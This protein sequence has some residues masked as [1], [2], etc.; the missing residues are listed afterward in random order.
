MKISNILFGCLLLVA[1]ASCDESVTIGSSVIEDEIE[2]VMDSSYT[3]SGRSIENTRIQSRTVTQ[4]LGSINAKEY[5]S[6]KSDFVT[7]LM[8]ANKIDTT[9]VTAEDIDSIKMKL[10]MPLGG[11][12]G[13]SIVPMGLNVYRLN[14]QLPSPIYSD[15]NPAE[16]YSEADLLCSKIYTANALGE[17]DSV[18]EL[19]YRFI[20]IDLPVELGREFFN[21]YKENPEI[22]TIPTEFAKWFPGLYVANKFGNGRVIQIE[23][24]EIKLFYHKKVPIEYTDRDTTYYKEGNYFAVTPEIITNN[25]IRLAMADDLQSMADNGEAVIVAPTG[26]DVELVFPA[27]E[28]IE[29]YRN[30]AGNLSVVNALSFEIPAE[31]ITNEYGINPPPYLLFVKSSEKDSFFANSNITDEVSSFYA[32]YNESKNKYV[33][34]DMRQYII[35]MLKKDEITDEDVTFTLTPINI[36]TESSSSSYYTSSTTYINDVTPYVQGPA[37]V[38]LKLDEAKIKFTYSKQTITN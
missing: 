32:T 18:A 10:F 6:L 33:F 14:K 37:M 24:I 15:F 3:V 17:N 16:Y 26:L 22:F 30:N 31:E 13:D 2:I 20:D 9:G 8:P 36:S 28:I 7:Q 21:K 1:L 25:N 29:S 5:G 4:L 27:R 23:S 34:T 12:T 11:Y 19:S 38:K 35:S